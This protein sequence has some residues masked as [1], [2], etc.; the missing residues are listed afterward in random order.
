MAA[1]DQDTPSPEARIAAAA[2]ERLFAAATFNGTGAADA[3]TG[4]AAGDRL[5]GRGGNDRLDGRGGRDTLDGGAGRDTLLGGAGADGLN[6]GGGNDSLDGGG[7][8]DSLGGGGGRDSLKGGGGADTLTGGAGAD[9]LTGGAGGDTFLFASADFSAPATD[10][11][12]DFA[13]G[14]DRVSLQGFA[15]IVSFADLEFA[16]VTGGVALELGTGRRIVFRGLDEG[17]LSA[18]D[19]GLP[20]GVDGGGGGSG[21]DGGTGGGGGGDGGSGGGGTGGGGSDGGGTGGGGTGGGGAPPSGPPVIPGGSGPDTLQGGAASEIVRGLGGDDV[22]GTSGGTDTLEGGDGAN[23]YAIRL[24]NGAIDPVFDRVADFQYGFGD[25]IGLS[26]A[27]AGVAFTD[28]SQVVSA[29]PSQGGTMIAVNRGGGFVNALLLEDVSF[30]VQQL[31]SYGFSLPPQNAAAFEANPYGFTNTSNTSADPTITRDGLF[32]AFV[33]KENIDGIA[34]DFTLPPQGQGGLIEDRATMDVFVRNMATGQIQRASFGTNEAAIGTRDGLP[35]APNESNAASSMSPAISADGR[36]VAFASDGRALAADTNSTGD[37]YLVDLLAAAQPGA[38]A[39]PVLISV[40]QGGTAA[41]GGVPVGSDFS[42]SS[43]GVLD[44]SANGTRVAFVTTAALDPGLDLNGTADI[45]VR[46]LNPLTGTGTTTL[47]SRAFTPGSNANGDAAGGVAN[48]Y[49]GFDSYQGDAVKISAD[50]RY[51]AYVTEGNHVAGSDGDGDFDL[52]LRDLQLNRT[53]FVSGVG[54]FDIQGFDMSADGSRLVFATRDALVDGDRNGGGFENG[55]DVYLAQV[56]LANFTSSLSRVSLAEGGSEI[57]GGNAFSPVI[58]PDGTRVAFISDAPDVIPVSPDTLLFSTTAL[59]ERNL[60][61]GAI[62]VAPANFASDSA[63]GTQFTRVAHDLSDSNLAFR[64]NIVAG[65]TIRVGPSI[66]PP[67][68]ADIP[69]NG[70]GSISLSDVR[71]DVIRSVINGAG[72]ADVFAISQGSN[73][74]VSVEG[75]GGGGGSLANARV[76]IIRINANGTTTVL[77]SDDN[78]GLDNDAFLRFAGG[79]AGDFVRV[80][81]VGGATGSYRLRFDAGFTSDDIDTPLFLAEDVPVTDSLFST[82]TS[83]W[84]KFDADDLGFQQRFRVNV[85][86][87]GGNPLTTPIIRVRDGDGDVVSSV[88]GSTIT[89]GAIAGGVGFIEID[90]SSDTGS[91]IVELLDEAI[92]FT[93]IIPITPIF[94]ILTFNDFDAF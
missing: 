9:L 86:Q 79:A 89:F 77:A 82:T 2:A 47:V 76:E 80:T 45:Y 60:G 37:V 65:D 1:T 27:L 7:G 73:F 24:L 5:T 16:A 44:I 87:T 94:P 48:P 36:F 88:V 67:A 74:S 70:T 75:T 71:G 30:T 29:T 20:E 46:T 19:F 41:A 85:S 40:A 43:A 54:E 91:Y 10:T 34:G 8:A 57:H 56:N 69:A 50:G 6:G 11:I 84:F 31:A 13:P 52:Y 55:M 17:D 93:P 28:L 25:R 64:T 14:A 23:T 18:A 4:G 63:G 90:S 42:T 39:D 3:L 72:D 59:Y 32:V 15:G 12:A 49:S 78:S 83:D 35:L 58:S 21:G 92:P 26:E 68:P 62:R 53:L 81:G 22:L 66:V 51:V 38:T 61:T 33:D